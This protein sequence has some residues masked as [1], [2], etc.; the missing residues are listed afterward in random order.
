MALI[1]RM[2]L[3]DKGVQ[4]LNT[5]CSSWV[6]VTIREM[7]ALPPNVQVRTYIWALR[8]R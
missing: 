2:L 3:N 6:P 7:L 8:E 1:R 5:T 4:I